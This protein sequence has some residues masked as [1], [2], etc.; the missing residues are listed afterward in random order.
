MHPSPR[1]QNIIAS[2]FRKTIFQAKLS[3]LLGRKHIQFLYYNWLIVPE[4]YFLLQYSAVPSW[5]PHPLAFSKPYL[6][7]KWW[8][9]CDLCDKGQEFTE[10][11][12]MACGILS[13]ATGWWFHVNM[14]PLWHTR[15]IAE[16]QCCIMR[17]MLNAIRPVEHTHWK[18]NNILG[19]PEPLKHLYV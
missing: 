12:N 2:R 17:Y 16:V 19:E 11:L 5:N 6:Q 8:Y 1:C 3:F 10:G 13:A 7:T 9:H 14:T 15:G 18:E 4:R